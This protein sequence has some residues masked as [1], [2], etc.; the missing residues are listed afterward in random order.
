MS[1]RPQLPSYPTLAGAYQLGAASAGRD[2]AGITGLV[3]VGLATYCVLALSSRVSSAAGAADI[4][5]LGRREDLES[6]ADG[7]IDA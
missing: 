1:G 2:A 5:P 3:G 4:P 7:S 6:Q